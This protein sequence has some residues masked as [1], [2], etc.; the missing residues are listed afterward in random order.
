MKNLSEFL[1]RLASGRPSRD[2]LIEAIREINNGE[3]LNLLFTAAD[4]ARK[5]YVGD[6]VHLRGIV[7]FSNQ[8]SE[9]CH[10]CGIRRS[11]AT[12]ER[13]RM[14]L[15]EIE[16]GALKGAELGF[17]TVVLQSGTDPAYTATILAATIRRIKAKADVAITLSI[18]ERP[19][20]DY[21]ALREAGA[22]R[23]L[24]KHETADQALYERLH[25]AHSLVSVP[26]LRERSSDYGETN[27][28]LNPLL[29]EGTCPAGQCGQAFV[30]SSSSSD[31]WQTTVSNGELRGE[32]ATLA[33]RLRCIRDL[34]DLGYQ[35]GAGNMVGL[36]GQTPESLADDILLMR[37]L[38]VD[39]A[40]IGPFIP[41]PN[42]P[43][44]G[45]SLVAL[46]EVLKIV[47]LTRLVLKDVLLPATTATETLARGGRR[48]ALMCGANVLMP[49]IT[50]MKYRPLYEIYPGKVCITEDA[51]DCSS[52]MRNM[53]EGIGRTVATGYGHSHRKP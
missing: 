16:L 44:A 38:E 30:S 46:E 7:E 27:T 6:E 34:K 39:M 21:A 40:G 20:E 12:L 31:P 42:T 50:P 23:F 13:Y 36:P 48:R 24:L 19:K 49:N 32:P 35:V 53:V 2:D 29:I 47:A 28:P 52:C 45:A 37:D 15:A 10:Y 43:L 14:D 9:D 25:A 5:A 26:D 8:C 33:R 51:D 1:G 41:H 4:T 18:G 17:R 3:D 22:D 11:N